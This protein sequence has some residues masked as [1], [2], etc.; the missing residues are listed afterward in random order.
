MKL[1]ELKKTSKLGT[2]LQN[3]EQN[4]KNGNKTFKIVNKTKKWKHNLKL[5]TNGPSEMHQNYK[6]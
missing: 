1:P 4:F 3:W 2:K 5:R 6:N